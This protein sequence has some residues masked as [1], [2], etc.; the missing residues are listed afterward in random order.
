M[1]NVPTR[2]VRIM[3]ATAAT[4]AICSAVYSLGLKPYLA[5][6]PVVVMECESLKVLDADSPMCDAQELRLIGDGVPG[7][8]GIDSPEVGHAKCARERELGLLAKA[9]VE[10]LLPGLKHVEDT[11]IR[12]PYLRPL[13]R[14]RMKDKTLVEHELLK[15][16]LAVIWTSAYVPRWCDTV[17]KG[18][19]KTAGG[20]DD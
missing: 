3:Q 2:Y 10:S 11:G 18:A 1:I 6:V 15:R 4:V 19:P 7:I 5:Q 16:G 8:T 20:G 13:V 14:L 17:G 9:T 12:D